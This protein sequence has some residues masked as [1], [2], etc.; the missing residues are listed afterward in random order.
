[1]AQSIGQPL[2]GLSCKETTYSDAPVT[3]KAHE[4]EKKDEPQYLKN[5]KC[6]VFLDNLHMLYLSKE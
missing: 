2:L 3:I 5:T 4:N 1:V 6:S